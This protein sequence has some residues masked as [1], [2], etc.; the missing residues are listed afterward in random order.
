VSGS[1]GAH[2]RG[3]STAM[4]FG[5]SGMAVAGWS[6]GGEHRR[7]GR[8]AVR[9][10][11][12]I[13][14]ATLMLAHGRRRQATS[15]ARPL[16]GRVR[17]SSTLLS[18]DTSTRWQHKTHREGRHQLLGT[19]PGGGAHERRRQEQRARGK[20]ERSREANE[21]CLLFETSQ[22]KR[23]GG[24][25]SVGGSAQSLWRTRAR[26]WHGPRLVTSWGG[27]GLTQ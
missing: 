22:G 15:P 14:E 13:R 6:G 19:V 25:E 23:N 1:S 21:L 18:D 3:L 16:H 27:V 24:L 26:R 20:R 17:Q 5:R 4:G 12:R 11:G 7:L 9:C 8:E 2:Q 10:T